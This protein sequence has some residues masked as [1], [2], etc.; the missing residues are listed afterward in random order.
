MYMGNDNNEEV[1]TRIKTQ[2]FKLKHRRIEGFLDKTL[3][4]AC[5]INEIK[6]LFSMLDK[7]LQ[8]EILNKPW[9]DE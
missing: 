2:V 8:K 9:L 6:Y 1:V 4:S 3:L 7:D 5:L